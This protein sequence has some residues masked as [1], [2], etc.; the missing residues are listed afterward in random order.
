MEFTDEHSRQIMETHDTVNT[1]KAVLLGANGGTGLVKKIEDTCIRQE[2]LE[3]RHNKLDKKFWI[4]I[5]FLAGSGVL[6]TGIWAI[7]SNAGG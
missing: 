1:L 5:S 7:L 4:L 2:R 3:E 6:G